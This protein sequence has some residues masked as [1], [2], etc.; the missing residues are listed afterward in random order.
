MIT[1]FLTDQNNWEENVLARAMGY[2][3]YGIVSCMADPQQLSLLRQGFKTW[4]RWRKENPLLSPKLQ[5]ADLRGADLRGVDLTVANLIG[6]ALSRASLL[7]ADLGEANLTNADLAGANLTGAILMETL[8]VNLDLTQTLG[9]NSCTH[10]GPSVLDH[11]TLTQSGH[12]PLAFLRGCGLPEQLITYLPSLLSQAIQFY[13]CFIS[14]TH[15]DK[16]FARRLHDMLQ[17]RGIRCWLDEKQLLPGDDI[18]EE[19]D[20]AIRLW[21]KVLLVARRTH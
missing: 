8:F 6:A 1:S 9:L 7:D 20:R 13:S 3:R 18:Y 15:T 2:P 12:L 17:G 10:L 11:R 5:Q 4:N 19:V 21:D 14:Y 16:A